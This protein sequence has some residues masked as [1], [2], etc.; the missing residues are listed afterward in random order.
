MRNL[1]TKMSS[2]VLILSFVLLSCNEKQ[3]EVDT[4]G[5][6][7]NQP[8]EGMEDINKLVPQQIISVSQAVEMK[9]EYN[10]TVLPLIE[11]A[12][13]NSYHATDFAFIS[14]DSLRKYVNFLEKVEDLNNKKISG[15]RIYFAAYP[16]QSNFTSVDKEIKYKG[17]ETFFMAPTVEIEESDLSKEFPNLKHVP[18]SITP[19]GSNKYVGNFKTITNLFNFLTSLKTT[20]SLKSNSLNKTEQNAEDTSLIFNEMQLTPPPKR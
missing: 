20:N 14:L 5:I 1:K 3:K 7:G 8:I 16:N 13:G 9:N 18:F 17:R 4:Q 10:T 6:V 12:H 15:L 11:T 2:I 19:S